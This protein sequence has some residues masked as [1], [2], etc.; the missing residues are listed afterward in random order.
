MI[1]GR[2]DEKYGAIA[3]EMFERVEDAVRL[4]LPG[5][6]SLPLEQPRALA[7]AL[8]ELAHGVTE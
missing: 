7:G 2:E 6:H 5:G 1:T 4:C 3:D 8:V